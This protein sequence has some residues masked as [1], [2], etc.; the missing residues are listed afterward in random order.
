MQVHCQAQAF[1]A[2]PVREVFALTVDPIRFPDFFTGYGPIAGIESVQLEAP[3]RPGSIRRVRSKDGSELRE[4]V[5][6]GPELLDASKLPRRLR[7]VL[8]RGLDPDP[9]KRWPSMHALIARLGEDCKG[10]G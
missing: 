5:T 10:L 6:A 4:Q 9:A 8:R 3:L 7:S 2:G 1:V